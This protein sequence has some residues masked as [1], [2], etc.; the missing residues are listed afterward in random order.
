M[1]QLESCIGYKQNF[2]YNFQSRIFSKMKSS[3]HLTLK[4]PVFDSEDMK[5][6]KVKAIPFSKAASPDETA[7]YRNALSPNEIVESY[8]EI[9]TVQ[10]MI[11]NSVKNFGDRP[12]LGSRSR[13]LV[14]GQPIWSDY[15][16]KSYAEF[17]EDRRFFGAGMM[18]LYNE[19]V[20]EKTDHWFLGIYSVFHIN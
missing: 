4:V 10:D 17:D 9:K 19:S 7:V 6:L 14:K 16:Y 13:T 8:P 15:I 2:V 5:L 3:T 18:N 1:R 11:Q 20:T 12:F